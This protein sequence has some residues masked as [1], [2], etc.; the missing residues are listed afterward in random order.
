MWEELGQLTHSRFKAGNHS[1]AAWSSDSNYIIA[2]GTGGVIYIW[3]VKTMEI[4]EI[5]EDIHSAPI[6]C[7]AYKARDNEYASVD[8]VGG[9]VVWG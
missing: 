5:I 4:E 6:S 2:G 9:L 7:I 3:D 8:T 1:E